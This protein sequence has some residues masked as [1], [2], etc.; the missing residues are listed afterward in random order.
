MTSRIIRDADDVLLL[1]A[2]LGNMPFPY[3]V[4]VTKGASRSKAQNKLQRVWCSL[5]AA[6]L[7]NGNTAEEV[8]GET[9]LR[10]GVPIMRIASDTFCEKYDRLI[11]PLDYKVKLEFMMEPIDLPVTRIM[12]ST[13]KMEYLDGMQRMWAERGVSVSY[14]GDWI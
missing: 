12:N 8:R 7:S 9:K 11:K 6:A 3:T 14:P 4:D 10:I 5:I 2:F 1:N 13:Q